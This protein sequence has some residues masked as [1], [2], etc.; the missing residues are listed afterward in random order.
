ME[1]KNDRN[2]A[3][4][5]TEDSQPAAKNVIV[6]FVEY[7]FH[8]LNHEMDGFFDDHMAAFNQDLEDLTD[9]RGET[10]EQYEI[11]Q[12]YL[13]ELESYF[14][15]F[16]SREGYESSS[17]CFDEINSLIVND[18][19]ERKKLF[20]EMSERMMAAF[21]QLQ[22]Q[23]EAA[24][25]EAEADLKDDGKKGADDDD[26]DD[27]KGEKASAAK[28]KTRQIKDS[29]GSRHDEDEDADD[30]KT[31]DVVSSSGQGNH[32]SPAPPVIMF[33]Q[34]VSLDSML[35]HVLS[36]TEYTTF[37]YIIRTKLKQ[38]QLYQSLLT[39]VEKQNKQ[40]TKRQRKF[41]RG[42][43]IDEIYEELVQRIC[44]FAPN[45]T[46]FQN[47]IR[48]HLDL[49]SWKDLLSGSG[50]LQLTHTHSL[51]HSTRIS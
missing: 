9:G 50:L 10:L 44:D 37:S 23:V 41:E 38:K 28:P 35:Q 51:T 21:S 29:K 5:Q 45:Q 18:E 24:E 8:I 46:Q 49:K 2:S 1:S 13:S 11:Y 47:Q 14:D 6:R 19:I 39:R 3:V 22:E 20:K 32:S 25:A 26:D 31:T 48:S 42:E 12:K 17:Q 7:S 43:A 34:P 36:L 33:F 16:A 4:T 40:T 27:V 15:E 30:A